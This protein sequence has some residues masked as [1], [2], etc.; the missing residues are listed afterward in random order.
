MKSRF[1]LS[2]DEKT[3]DKD[4]KETTDEIPLVSDAIPFQFT[5]TT[6]MAFEFQKFFFEDGFVT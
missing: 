4:D 2:G 6:A 5:H 1:G 3:K